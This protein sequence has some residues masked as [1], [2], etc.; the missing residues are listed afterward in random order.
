MRLRRHYGEAWSVRIVPLGIELQWELSSEPVR[1][2]F[3]NFVRDDMLGLRVQPALGVTFAS[4]NAA[5][6]AISPRHPYTVDPVTGFVF[7]N[8]LMETGRRQNSGWLFEASMPLQPAFDRFLNFVDETVDATGFFESLQTLDDYIAAIESGRWPF[9][10][11]MPSFL[12]ALVAVGQ[13]S[14]AKKLAAEH[15]ALTVQTAVDRGLVQHASDTQPYDE[16]QAMP[17]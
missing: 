4:V 13:T 2:V 15:R 5:R 9:F 3:F 8:D 14:K 16:I 7:L 10:S 6:D 11:V 1:H 12:Y 17:G